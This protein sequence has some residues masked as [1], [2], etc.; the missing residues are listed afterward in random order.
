MNFQKKGESRRKIFQRRVI[1]S[2]A[3]IFAFALCMNNANAMGVKPKA[4]V[5]AEGNLNI[6]EEPKAFAK[7][8]GKLEREEIVTVISTSNEEWTQIRTNEGET[9]YVSS[10]FL[11]IPE[12][13][14]E[15]YE[16]IS[17]S[18]ITKIDGSS[19][20][21]NFN[22]SKAAEE[23]NGLILQHNET[24]AWYDVKDDN[25]KTIVEGVVGP[26]SK[27][28][29]YKK[30][31]ILVGGKSATGYGGGV[32]QVS[33]AL[34]NCIYKIGIEPEERHKHSK[35]SSYV[36]KGM[37]ATV[38]YSE[39]IEYLKNFVFTNTEEYPIMFETYAEGP[40]VVARA[41]IVY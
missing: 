37:D 17:V 11:V 40:Q 30:A 6:R 38:S 9:G 28:K 19:E 3:I 12:T 15:E 20:N 39:N 18:I 2:L 23:I 13:N 32:C 16:L 31:P 24:F 25:G 35:S 8:I 5:I 33:T 36:K 34:Y 14:A 26:A 22:M 10:Q 27:E 21:R 4:Y 29:G 7:V 1:T 41:Y